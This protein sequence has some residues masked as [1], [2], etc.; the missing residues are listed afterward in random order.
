MLGVS[1]SNKLSHSL[2]TGVFTLEFILTILIFVRFLRTSDFGLDIES[3]TQL[4]P[5]LSALDH[6]NYAR[7]L[8]VHIRDLTGLESKHPETANEFKA[9]KFTV[10]KSQR[11]FSAIAIDHAHVQN[12]AY[13]GA[14]GLMENSGSPRRWMLGGPEITRI[15]NEFD[16]QLT[17]E[18]TNETRHHKQ[19]SAVQKSFVEQV[20][21]LVSCL[22]E[23]G[24]HFWKKELYRKILPTQRCGKRKR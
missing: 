19:H 7:Y 13:G 4:A 16:D 23:T 11:F 10:Q 18:Y 21:A 14:V 20:T 17:T 1:T 9:D 8:P 6:T 2:N 12:N 3:L 24:I 15:I 22:E 5:W